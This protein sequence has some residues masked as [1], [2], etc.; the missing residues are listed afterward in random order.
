MFLANS[1][2]MFAKWIASWCFPGGPVVKNPPLS[3]GDV[4]L[5]PGPGTKIPQ[6]SG[7]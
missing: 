2:E 3:E 5:I 1:K 4:G 6:V 7:Q